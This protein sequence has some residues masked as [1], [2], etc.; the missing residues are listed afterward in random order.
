MES[1]QI[2]YLLIGNLVTQIPVIIVVII[3]IIFS[4]LKWSKHPKVAKVALGGLGIL[5]FTILLSLGLSFLRIQLPVLLDRNYELMG[6]IN[7]GI[8]FVQNVIWAFGLGL[9]IYAVWVG[10]DKS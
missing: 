9:L 2:L 8:S 3:G 7:T 4:F 1:T 10:R 5:F 6:Y